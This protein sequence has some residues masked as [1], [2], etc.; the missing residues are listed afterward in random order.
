MPKKAGGCTE[1]SFGIFLGLPPPW[2]G[3]FWDRRFFGSIG[4]IGIGIG[5]GIGS[6]GIG[7]GIGR[8]IQLE[9]TTRVDDEDRTNQNTI[10]TERRLK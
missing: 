6:I 10:E 4:S 9:S 2:P 7:I 5:I 1:T 3:I 8:I